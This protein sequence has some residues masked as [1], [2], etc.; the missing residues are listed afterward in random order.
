MRELLPNVQS[1]SGGDRVCSRPRRC[2]LS[3]RAPPRVIPRDHDRHNRGLGALVWLALRYSERR[4]SEPGCA[5]EWIPRDPLP[6]GFQPEHVATPELRAYPGRSHPPALP[7]E[8]CNNHQ[9]PEEELRA[10]A[11]ERSLVCGPSQLHRRHSGMTLP[12]GLP[13]KGARYRNL[14]VDEYWG[15]VQDMN[16]NAGSVIV[17]RKNY[18]K[19]LQSQHEQKATARDGAGH[20]QLR[21]DRGRHGCSHEGRGEQQQQGQEEQQGQKQGAE[22]QRGREEEGRGEELERG[23]QQGQKE[24]LGK[25]KQEHEE[26]KQEQKEKQEQQGQGEKQEQ[27]K[28][29][30]E[31]QQ[32]QEQQGQGEKQEQEEK[33]GQEKQQEEKQQ[34]KQ[35][36]EEK[37]QEKQE[38]EEKQGQEKQPEQEEKQGQEK[39][40]EQEEKQGQELTDGLTEA[41][42]GD[43]LPQNKQRRLRRT[44]FTRLQVNELESVFQ[45]IQYPDVSLR[46][47]LAVRMDLTETRVQVWFK[48]RRVKW[49]K[50]Q[51]ASMIG[52]MPPVGQN[53][54]SGIVLNGLFSPCSL[55]G[56]GF[57]W[58]HSHLSCICHPG[59]PYHL[60]YPCQPCLSPSCVPF[61]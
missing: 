49:R 52:N 13:S 53:H 36:Q 32:E 34:E 1:A 44:T 4:L 19:Q 56:N 8:D 46:Q 60:G 28:Q 21:E 51:K 47:E 23:K 3:P 14:R 45:R 17:V 24:K 26:R 15:E 33:Q 30:Q 58:N 40:Q 48:N 20:K 38:Q 2:V 55:I 5:A 6:E 61:T 7:L 50:Y 39:Q 37:Q 59:Y 57:F 31:K 54:P 10:S 29:G 18:E 12:P 22:K 11:P 25:K 43:A 27:E 42:T 16:C 9:V 41:A 35:E